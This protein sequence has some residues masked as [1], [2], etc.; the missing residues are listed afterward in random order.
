MLDRRGFFGSVASASLGCFIPGTILAKENKPKRWWKVHK[1]I[2]LVPVTP[3]SKEFLHVP[4][5]EYEWPA[6]RPIFFG[7]KSGVDNS[8]QMRFLTFGFNPGW[9]LTDHIIEFVKIRLI[10]CNNE[11]EMHD[12]G[13]LAVRIVGS[14]REAVITMSDGEDFYPWTDFSSTVPACVVMTDKPRYGLED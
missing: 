11:R 4:V 6:D 3:K 5:T 8:H 2:L 9:T 7:K 12:C 14:P 1:Y 13:V 10:H